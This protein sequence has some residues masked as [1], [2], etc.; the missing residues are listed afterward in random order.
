MSDRGERALDPADTEVPAAEVELAP[1]ATVVLLRDGPAG[2]EALL[3]RRNPDLAFHGGAWVFPGGRV[4]AQDAA[5]AGTA[6]RFGVTAARHAAARELTEEA[7][8]VAPVEDLVPWSHWVT[9]PG[10]PRRFATWFFVAAE[11]EVEDVVVDGDEIH[12]SDWVTPAAAFA[13][14]TA[15]EMDLAP[16]TWLTL[17]QV[18]ELG[19]VSAV[20]THADA[21]DELRYEPRISRDT[22]GALVSLYQ[23]DAGW[24]TGD[25]TVD[26][27][28]HRLIWAEAGYRFERSP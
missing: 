12:A 26:G 11:A 14:C 2:I 16:P 28:R 7:D 18:A 24:P 15:R 4:D 25:A 17:R 10:P 9:P 6:D 20:L 13:R 21:R 5:R 1:A 23:G 3:L 19:S 27:A 8:L 22:T